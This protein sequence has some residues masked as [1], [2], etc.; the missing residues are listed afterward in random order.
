MDGRAP[1]RAG[2]TML[3][4]GEHQPAESPGSANK[5]NILIQTICSL[6]CPALRTVPAVNAPGSSA[7]SPG[8]L[9]HALRY[10]AARAH[11]ARVTRR[12]PRH[13]AIERVAALVVFG[14]LAPCGCPSTCGEQEFLSGAY[15]RAIMSC[16]TRIDLFW[17]YS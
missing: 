11:A 4:E 9:T 8:E 13:V 12:R 10:A 17:G 6:W 14:K 3:L 16:S 5:K 15:P 1:R 7:S 2:Q